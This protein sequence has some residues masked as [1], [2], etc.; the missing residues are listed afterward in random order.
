M[1]GE[2]FK[3]QSGLDPRSTYPRCYFC[4]K[5]D[6]NNKWTHGT[7]QLG[8]WWAH[9]ECAAD[10]E[11]QA[12]LSVQLPVVDYAVLRGCRSDWGRVTVMRYRIRQWAHKRM[13]ALRQ[14]AAIRGAS[15]MDE[16]EAEYLW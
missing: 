6:E 13:L 5:K 12:L 8:R 4:A 16:T 15:L 14:L 2:R 11:N 1:G 7:T 9:A 10:L 3:V